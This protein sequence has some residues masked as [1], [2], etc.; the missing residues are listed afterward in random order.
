MS[1]AAGRPGWRTSS[2]TSNGSACVEVAPGPRAVRVRDTKD[3]GLGPILLLD[4][5]A[6]AQLRA[7]AVAG[8]A[9]A[10]GGLSIVHEARRTE[11]AGRTVTTA[12]HVSCGGRVVHYTE[13][14]WAAF[15]AGVRAGEFE[16]AP[17]R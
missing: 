15:A 14:E 13:S 8:P 12:W 5:A 17:A 4:H 1:T 16:F 11:H 6:W 9:G 3:R 10:V 2:F 7:A